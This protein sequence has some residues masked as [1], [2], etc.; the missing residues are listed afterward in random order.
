MHHIFVINPSQT[1]TGISE[2]TS[3]ARHQAKV[4][5]KFNKWNFFGKISLLTRERRTASIQATEDISL[6]AVN[7]K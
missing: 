2:I 1:Q 3:R 4:L 7:Q 6:I 5:S